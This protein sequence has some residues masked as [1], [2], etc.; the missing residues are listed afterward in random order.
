MDISDVDKQTDTETSTETAIDTTTDT[1]VDTTTD[2]STSTESD[3]PVPSKPLYGDVDCN[4]VVNMED[5]VALQKI[6]AKLTTHEQYGEMSRINS[7]CTHEGDINM[8]DVTEIQKF[9]AKLIP[10][11][12][13]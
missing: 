12:D 8:V 5:V 10:D 11:L 13:P 6:M 2:T 9:L 1:A 3:E 4:G 7:D